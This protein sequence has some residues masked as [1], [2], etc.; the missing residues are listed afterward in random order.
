M[1]ATSELEYLIL[2]LLTSRLES[3]LNMVV[4]S[5]IVCLLTRVGSFGYN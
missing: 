1:Y 5:I 2:R 4:Y 3:C